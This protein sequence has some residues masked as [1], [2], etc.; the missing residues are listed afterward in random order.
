MRW[1]SLIGGFILKAP[2]HP[3]AQKY[4]TVTLKNKILNMIFTLLS[5]ILLRIL[6]NGVLEFI[7]RIQFIIMQPITNA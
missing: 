5:K 4:H 2:R 7:N 1:H 3:Y 6:F